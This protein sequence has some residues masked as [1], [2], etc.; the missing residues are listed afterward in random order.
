MRIMIETTRVAADR[1]AAELGCHANVARRVAR[2][3][4]AVLGAFISPAV[5]KNVIPSRA[6]KSTLRAGFLCGWGWE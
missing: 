2:G 5:H 6:A 3:L 1:D 4:V